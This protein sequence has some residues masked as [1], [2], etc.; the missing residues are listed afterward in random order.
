M[1]DT[2][3]EPHKMSIAEQQLKEGGAWHYTVSNTYNTS[4]NYINPWND[5]QYVG[6]V[7][8][9]RKST[10]YRDGQMYMVNSSTEG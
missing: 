1:V 4:Y 9:N 7:V 6:L 2:G 10:I 5:R 8:S 3:T